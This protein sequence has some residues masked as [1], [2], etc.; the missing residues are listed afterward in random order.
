[1]STRYY[2]CVTIEHR[3][4]V[5]ERRNLGPYDERTAD[6]VA[7]AAGPGLWKAYD[8]SDDYHVHATTDTTPTEEYHR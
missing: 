2:V 5:I 3:G 7:F 1:M 6:A 4:T 8:Y